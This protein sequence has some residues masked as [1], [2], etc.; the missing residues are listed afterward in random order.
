MN[1]LALKLDNGRYAWL[2]DL[3][4][5]PGDVA[6]MAGFGCCKFFRLLDYWPDIGTYVVSVDRGEI[7][8]VIL[9][10]AHTADAVSVTGTPHRNPKNATLF[11]SETES[12]LL[13]YSLQVWELTRSHWRK[14]YDCRDW[15]TEP[16]LSNGRD[17]APP[18]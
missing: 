12:D 8:D 13:G 1:L 11:V 6:K 4:D 15:R 10:S 14:V 9:I 2:V 17:R 7:S 5:N 3:G 18:N 16:D